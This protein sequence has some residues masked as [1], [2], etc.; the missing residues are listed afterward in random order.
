MTAPSSESTP[1]AASPFT[2]E[3]VRSAVEAL[4][5]GKVVGLPTETVYG[6][7]VRADLESALARLG[8][9]LEHD[10]SGPFTW[11][12][13]DPEALLQSSDL[14]SL[15]RRLAERYWPGPLTLVLQGSVHQGSG[16]G[17]MEES[18]APVGAALLA[19]D[20]LLAAGGWTGVRVPSHAGTAA[21]LEAAPFPVVLASAARGKAAPAVTASGV[22]DA[23][24]E[25]EVPL[26][27]D[28]GPASLQ[29]PSTVLALGPGRFEVLREGIVTP[30]ELRRATGLS[31]LFVCTGNT[32][33]SPMAEG[34][35][36]AAIQR[37]LGSADE[38]AFGFHVASA[39]VY[40]GVGS[41]PSEHAVTVLHDRSIDLS[42]HQSH[43]AIPR[44]IAAADRVYCL[45][46]S[47]RSALL[48]VL[49]PGAADA[50]ELLDPA[51]RDVPDPFGGPLEVYR[52]T[53]DVIEGF[54]EARLPAW[55]G[56]S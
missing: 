47:H 25:S 27:L 33:R 26:V 23:F 21:V 50:V 35:A 44:E 31:I 15:A 56:H 11:H 12:T 20:G 49:P 14:G 37:A 43:P 30:A 3:Q 41:P 5:D 42:G 54:I 13:T 17:E 32:C 46:R 36:R 7:A 45:T 1:L 38:T 55:V 16:E 18:Q 28:G 8:S 51:G 29:T 10:E 9:L 34:I 39:G 52:R 22:R 19:T 2:E 40:A 6:L 24:T 4:A 53:A 48:S